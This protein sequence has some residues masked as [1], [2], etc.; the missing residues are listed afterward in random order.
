MA[1]KPHETAPSLSYGTEESKFDVGDERVTVVEA[2]MSL[3]V[4]P[5]WVKDSDALIYCVDLSQATPESV[6]Y[7]IEDIDTFQRINPNAKLILVGTHIDQ[8][9]NPHEKLK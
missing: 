8:A 6:Q 3:D 4:F 2:T 9:K 7:A 1:G 5:L